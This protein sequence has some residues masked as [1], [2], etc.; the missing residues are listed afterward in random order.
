[1][2][3]VNGTISNAQVTIISLS[4]ET[5]LGEKEGII[6]VLKFFQNKC[7]I[8]GGILEKLIFGVFEPL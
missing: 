7:I 3:L 6:F 8:S 4:V 2:A 5:F 1:M